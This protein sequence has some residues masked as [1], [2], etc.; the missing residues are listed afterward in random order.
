[1]PKY[2]L[3][4]R[5]LTNIL[6]DVYLTGQIM[7]NT[8]LIHNGSLA[9]GN[10]NTKRY[11][12]PLI[13]CFLLAFIDSVTINAAWWLLPSHVTVQEMS[14]C[15]WNSSESTSSCC[16]RG[17]ST[18]GGGAGRGM[19][20]TQ[21]GGRCGMFRGLTCPGLE[22]RTKWVCCCILKIHLNRQSPS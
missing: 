13:R 2:S 7:K 4:L 20:P 12:R 8:I 18:T 11:L 3:I 6:F 19:S 16:F 21:P 14:G 9:T 5:V 1:M 22:A 17:D 10:V 15:L